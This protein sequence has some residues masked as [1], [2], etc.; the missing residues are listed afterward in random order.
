MM[1]MV[2]V[3]ML[4]E[5]LRR[6]LIGWEILIMRGS[7]RLHLLEHRHG[8]DHLSVLLFGCRA[9]R[10]LAPI[11]TTA[12]IIVDLHRALALAL[13]LVVIEAC[14]LFVLGSTGGSLAGDL[15]G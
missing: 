11:T 15:L 5:L 1:V 12:L 7:T 9:T 2:M 8:G 6:F 13:A 3:V 4:V 14:S 10:L